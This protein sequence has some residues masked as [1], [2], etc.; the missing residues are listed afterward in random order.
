MQHRSHACMEDRPRIGDTRAMPMISPS[1]LDAELPWSPARRAAAENPAGARFC[2]GC[3][4]ALER[5]CGS[6]GEPVPEGARFC[7]ACGERWMRRAPASL[8]AGSRGP[9]LDA[10]E[11]SVALASP[12]LDERRTVTVLF[13]D[14]SGYTAVAARL[15]PESVKR[16]LERILGR[17]GEEVR[18]LR[19]T[20]RQVHRRQR[21]GDL[22][23]PGRPRRR[24]G[25]RRPR[26]PRACRRRWARSTSRW[27]RS[28]A[29]RSSCAWAS[30]P[31]RCSRATSA[32]AT[33]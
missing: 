13:A 2:M 7:M 32:T 5:R 16:Q 30:T 27:P 10:D 3:G 23:R 12:T 6:C 14:L 24:R 20:C 19:G 22:R 21:D 11:P 18:G 29:S 26:G 9:T 15:D 4:A 25:A 1:D 33:R 28:T 8:P 31:A 17:L